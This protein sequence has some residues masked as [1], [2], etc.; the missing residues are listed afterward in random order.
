MDEKTTLNNNRNTVANKT[1]ESL[2]HIS[3]YAMPINKLLIVSIF[4]PIFIFYWGYKN[5][6]IIK[7][8]TNTKLSPFWR[9]IFTPFTLYGIAKRVRQSAK[10]NGYTGGF[11]PTAIAI[12]FFIVAFLNISIQGISLNFIALAFLLIPIQKA[13]NYNNTK[14]NPNLTLTFT[15]NKIE[16]IFFI[17]GIIGTVWSVLGA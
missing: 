9:G 10:I 16:W 7:V 15:L 5:W 8:E 11:N 6:K 1:D 14:L 3:Y 4:A 2:G 12:I 13:I 17:L